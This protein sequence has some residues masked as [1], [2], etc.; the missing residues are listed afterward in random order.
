MTN[1]SAHILAAGIAN[2]A[3]K[4]QLAELTE[5]YP[6]ERLLM[7]AGIAALLAII[8][9]VRGAR[10]RWTVLAGATAVLLLIASGAHFFARGFIDVNNREI[11]RSHGKAR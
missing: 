1:I 8:F 9:K 3:L 4:A 5:R 7:G 6:L 2:P 11:Q 10:T